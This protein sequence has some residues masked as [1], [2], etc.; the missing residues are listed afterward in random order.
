MLKNLSIVFVF[1]LTVLALNFS[2]TNSFA[3][4]SKAICGGGKGCTS[5]HK[6]SIEEAQS[7]VNFSGATVKSVKYSEAV[8]LY[9]LLL[10]KGGSKGVLF[11]DYPKKHIIQGNVL[12][13]KTMKLVVAHEKDL[14]APPKQVTDIDLK[15]A[16][17]QYAV[18]MGDPKGSKKLYV[19]T[20]PDCPY[21]RQLH[22]QLQKLASEYKDIA[23]NIMLMP[24]Q[25]HPQAYDKARAIMATK[26]IKT[27]DDAFSGKSVTTPTADAGKAGVD[28]VLKF[29]QAAGINGTPMIFVTNGKIFNGGRD[30]ESLAAALGAT[31]Q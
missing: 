13:V 4:S 16:P 19:F 27:L 1:A 9:E 3:E 12:D 7:I 6:L 22:P 24:L 11:V 31:K 26:D 28:A 5:C 30:A 17:L 25:M 23:I 29:S 14:P 15:A 21:C 2:L 8:G 18:V 20:D 10:E